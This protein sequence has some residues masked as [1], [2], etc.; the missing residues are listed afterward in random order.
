[1]KYH[2]AAI[3]LNIIPTVVKTSK[4]LDLEFKKYL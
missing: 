1:M 4:R 2:G 3:N